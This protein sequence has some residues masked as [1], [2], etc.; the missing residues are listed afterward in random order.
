MIQLL[1]IAALFQ[2]GTGVVTGQLRSKEG[3]PITGVRISAMTAPEA[4]APAPALVSMGLTDNTG[5]YRLENIPPGRYYITSGFIEQPTYYPG[6]AS[7]TGATIV[8]VAPGA[9]VT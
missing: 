1:V 8:N 9:T 6:V 4:N 3:Q 7:V 2:V 5:H